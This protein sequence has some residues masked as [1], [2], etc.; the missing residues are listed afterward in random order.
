MNSISSLAIVML[1]TLTLTAAVAVL[2]LGCSGSCPPAHGTL[3]YAILSVDHVSTPHDG[4]L[5]DRLDPVAHCFLN[6][7]GGEWWRRRV[8]RVCEAPRRG[9]VL[10]AG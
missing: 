3:T 2:A 7:R 8:P 10:C 1:A 5:V 9:P 6:S 4:A